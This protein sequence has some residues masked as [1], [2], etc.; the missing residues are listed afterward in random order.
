MSF[1]QAKIF[2]DIFKQC[3]AEADANDGKINPDNVVRHFL[4]LLDDAVDKGKYY[5][6]YIYAQQ[7]IERFGLIQGYSRMDYTG[8]LRLPNA[9]VYWSVTP[10]GKRLLNTPDIVRWTFFFLR[11]SWRKISGFLAAFGFITILARAWS[12]FEVLEGW[13]G[14]VAAAFLTIAAVFLS[15]HKDG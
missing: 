7:A 15:R 8:N 2:D 1:K 10:F 3:A 11:L 4:G 13:M 14:Y 9:S 5:F 12:G 6:D